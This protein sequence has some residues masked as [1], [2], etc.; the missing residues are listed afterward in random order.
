MIG[1]AFSWGNANV[2]TGRPTLQ[3]PR[4]PDA[5]DLAG[6]ATGLM[7]YVLFMNYIRYGSLKPWFQAKFFNNVT[8]ADQQS[9]DQGQQL[10]ATI[11]GTP[12]A[13]Q[14]LSAAAGIIPGL[15]Q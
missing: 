2:P 8:A 14:L 10:A 9:I 4:K 6:F 1:R 13:P 12:Q 15:G 3:V 7:A 5:G 11:I